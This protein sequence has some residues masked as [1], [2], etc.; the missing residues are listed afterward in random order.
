MPPERESRLPLIAAT[1]VIT[2]LVTA[3]GIWVW[4][5]F[6]SRR[7]APIPHL[8][9]P[10]KMVAILHP[11]E[12]GHA[13]GSLR[14]EI[15]ASDFDQIMQ[16]ITPDQPLGGDS[17]DLIYQLVA[18]VIIEHEDQSESRVLI[19]DCGKN[20]ALV[21]VNGRDYFF[22]KPHTG[23]YSSGAIELRALVL[24]IARGQPRG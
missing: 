16:I 19:R 10:T 8:A 9:A 6:I 4:F 11:I 21:T 13:P 14:V 12:D 5:T 1:A 3:I 7:P 20:P 23:K 18:E 2:F 24:Q 22:A 17:N 15:P